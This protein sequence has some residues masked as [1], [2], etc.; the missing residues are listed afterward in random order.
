MGHTYRKDWGGFF[1][2]PMGWRLSVGSGE[3]SDWL[4]ILRLLALAVPPEK[5]PPA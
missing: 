3:F 4:Q 1:G 5:V 2:I